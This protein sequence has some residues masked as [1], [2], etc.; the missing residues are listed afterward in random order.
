MKKIMIALA[1]LGL[2]GIAADAQTCVAPKKKVVKKVASCRRPVRKA[3]AVRTAQVCR[4]MGGF[5]SCCITKNRV[6][7]R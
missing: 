1:L 2:T 5:Y 6:A 4:D 7:V 3:T